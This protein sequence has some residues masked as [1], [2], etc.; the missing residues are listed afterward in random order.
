[1]APSPRGG[2]F[3]VRRWFS[4]NSPSPV[5]PRGREVRQT[6][7]RASFVGPSSMWAPFKPAKPALECGSSSYRLP[8]LV[9]PRSRKG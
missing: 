3:H 5:G 9:I 8:P 1:M 2:G 6:R 4:A 7:N